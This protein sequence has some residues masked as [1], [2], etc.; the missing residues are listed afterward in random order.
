MS[1]ESPVPLWER[2]MEP[3][4]DA[5]REAAG[6][7]E[8]FDAA[9]I[10]GLRRHWPV[11]LVAA[12]VELTLARR[13]ARRKFPHADELVAD[14]AGVEQATSHLVAEH[15]ARRYAALP[16][17]QR[18]RAVVDL[19]CGIGGDAMSLTRVAA[20]RGIDVSPLRAWM[21]AR[22]AGCPAE[23]A[24]V[25]SRPLDGA[26]FHLDPARRSALRTERRFWRYED[27]EPGPDFIERLL[28][29]CPDGAIKLGP[30]VDFDALPPGE[31]REVEIINERGT[32]VQAILWCGRLALHAG[33]RT[34]TRLPESLSC[35]GVPRPW[36]RPPVGGFGRFLVLVDPAVERAGLAGV[37]CRTLPVDE[38]H[39]GLGVL[40]SDEPVDDPWLTMFEVLARMPWRIE[41]IG[42]W[43]EANGAGVVEVKTR[44]GAIDPDDVQ[45]RV[46]GSGAA[47]FTL[48]GLRL[49]RKLVA[50]ITRRR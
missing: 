24:D 5:L 17:H 4:N 1:D 47:S 10:E 39:P 29:T 31:D 25:R 15:K 14:V 11:E 12:A 37:V 2:L 42:A 44:G 7:V 26:I 22:N 6:R 9:A 35:T 48:F 41:R 33:A 20:V 34:A 3:S 27:C 40:T 43:L 13:K 28:R 50:V 38:V 23:A 32:L 16:T 49:D 18:S 45:R 8:V 46:R 36:P 30:G 21:T 19:C